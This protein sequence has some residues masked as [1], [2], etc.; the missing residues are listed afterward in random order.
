MELAL[1]T[2]LLVILSV[3]LAWVIA[4]GAAQ[5][6]AN[7]A[8][9]EAARIVARGESNAAAESAARQILGP[10]T[11]AVNTSPDQ[12]RVHVSRRFSGPGPVLSRLGFTVTADAVTVM[13]RS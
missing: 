8:A 9:R 1:A 12:V 13:E 4:L 3:S 10:A 7:D 5:A 2:P 6:R 11:V